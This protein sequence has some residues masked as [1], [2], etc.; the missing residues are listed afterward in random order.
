MGVPVS[1]GRG[2]TVGAGVPGV[3]SEGRVVDACRVAAAVPESLAAADAVGAGVP[4]AARTAPVAPSEGNAI[5]ANSRGALRPTI[6]IP[7]RPTTAALA[8]R[9]DGAL[10]RPA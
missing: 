4:T 5:P 2:A 6:A 3:V 9:S 8:Q 7:I 1:R 10:R